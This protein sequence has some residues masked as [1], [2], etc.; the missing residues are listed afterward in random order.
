VEQHIRSDAMSIVTGLHAKAYRILHLAG[1]GVHEQVLGNDTLM[2]CEMCGQILQS[3]RPEKISGMIIGQNVFLTPADVEQMRQVPE[4]VFINCCHLGRTDL[5]AQNLSQEDYLKL[6]GNRHKLAANVAAQFIRMG[7]K[8]IVAA[9][10]AVDDGAAKTFAQKFY[11]AMLDGCLFGE[12]VRKAREEA[13]QNHPGVNTWGAYQCYGDPDYRLRIINRQ[14]GGDTSTHPFVSPAEMAMELSNFCSH[15]QSAERDRS[16]EFKEE[17]NQIV[18][19]GKDSWQTHAEVAAALGLAYGELGEFETAVKHLDLALKANKA[20]LTVRAVEQ[21]ANY[22]CKWA[23]E[24]DQVGKKGR[25]ALDPIAMINESIRELEAIKSFGSTAERLCLLG[26]AFKRLAILSKGED[27]IKALTSMEQ[28]YK[29]AHDLAYNA[30]NGK[31]DSYPLLNWLTA[32][33]IHHRYSDEGNRV[34]PKK[35]LSDI[36]MLCARAEAAA[37]ERDN[38]EP[39]IWNSLTESDALLVR[40]LAQGNIKEAVGDIV[41]GYKRAKERGASPRQ[42][43]SVIEHLDFVT[44]MYAEAPQ[45]LRLQAER[46]TLQE[47][48]DKLI[49]IG[50]E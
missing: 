21:R 24:I 10:W 50:G 13:Y 15:A 32:Q 44:R 43:G 48:K 17:L 22:R 39:D 12:A 49:A 2:A 40:A 47:L 23:V 41:A 9:G 14:G 19:R 26:S 37:A 34:L 29:D 30:G 6:I 27:R 42:F 33:I 38:V 20:A 7:V 35:L 4:L 45:R 11:A 25:D 18:R 31:L 3:G 28:Y 46:D 36:Q 16:P 5:S 8:A 1:H